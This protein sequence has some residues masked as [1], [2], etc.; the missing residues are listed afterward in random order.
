MQHHLSSPFMNMA[1]PFEL[2]RIYRALGYC[3]LYVAIGTSGMWK[4]PRALLVMSRVGH[5][6]SRWDR[7]SLRTA[8]RLRN[9]T[10]GKP[11]RSCRNCSHYYVY[12]RDGDGDDYDGCGIHSSMK[13][14]R[15]GSAAR[16]R[17]A[18]LMR[19]RKLVSRAEQVLQDIGC[20][21]GQANQH[22]GV[23]E[24]SGQSG[25]KHPGLLRAVRRGRRSRLEPRVN[26]AQLSDA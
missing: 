20:D 2:D 22:G 14:D 4:L 12:A 24:N 6:R 25:S 7:R 10:W 21:A 8:P 15:F 18:C 26:S 1:L 17:T 9:A 13:S 16:W 11:G 23:V 19:G 3:T 5:R